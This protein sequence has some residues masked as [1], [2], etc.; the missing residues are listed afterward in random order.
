MLYSRRMAFSSLAH[1]NSS[2]LHL[3]RTIVTVL[4]RGK[5]MPIKSLQAG[6]KELRTS[7]TESRST[8][9]QNK[10]GRRGRLI[11]VLPQHRTCRFQH[12]AFRLYANLPFGNLDLLS[13]NALRF[14]P[15][16]LVSNLFSDGHPLTSSVLL[17]IIGNISLIRL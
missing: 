15:L 16:P 3:R 10:S 7:L 9:M 1:T 4:H 12:P 5:A 13:V 17:H 8:L 11:P 14:H 2:N 6:L